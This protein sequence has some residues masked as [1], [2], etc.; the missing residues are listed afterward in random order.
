MVEHGENN[1]KEIVIDPDEGYIIKEVLVNNKPI[2]INT[3]DEGIMRIPANYFTNVQEDKEVIVQFEKQNGILIINKVDA[4][5]ENKGLPNAEFI[6]KKT[7]DA[8]NYIGELMNSDDPSD[9]NF[10]RIDGKY[11]SSNEG[12]NNSKSYGRIEIDL[13]NSGGFHHLVI[14]AKISSESG[15]HGI[16]KLTNSADSTEE[17]MLDISGE[18]GEKFYY[19]SLYGNKKWYVTFIYDKDSAEFFWRR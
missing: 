5:D 8:N 11:I 19:K 12:I 13:G 1:T 15:D 16:I 17:T 7:P 6:V 9:K 4:K 3:D 10:N 18:T 2:S 14:N